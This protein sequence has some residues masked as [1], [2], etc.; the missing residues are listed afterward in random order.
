MLKYLT[1]DAVDDAKGA[2]LQSMQYKNVQKPLSNAEMDIGISTKQSMKSVKSDH[3]EILPLDITLS[4]PLSQ[5]TY[6]AI[7]H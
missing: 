1:R 3:Q 2:A 4:T 5:N 7:S 6:S